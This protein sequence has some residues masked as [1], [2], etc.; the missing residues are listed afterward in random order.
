MNYTL[1]DS[2]E[3]KNDLIAH[4]VQFE[5]DMEAIMQNM[6]C[7]QIEDEDRYFEILDPLIKSGQLP[8]FSSFHRDSNDS[9]KR[10]KLKKK[11]FIL[12]LF[13]LLIT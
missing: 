8:A 1:A 13:V 11:V 12:S 9:N 6:M 7:S 2:D 5:G 4:Y 3:E 10:K